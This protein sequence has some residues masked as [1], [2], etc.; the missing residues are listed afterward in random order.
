MAL[1]NLDDRVQCTV[2]SVLMMMMMP[3]SVDRL[4]S[5]VEYFIRHFIIIVHT[6]KSSIT[7]EIAQ[8]IKQNSK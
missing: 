1:I 2:R 8:N 4:C 6:H 3:V 7:N 5:A